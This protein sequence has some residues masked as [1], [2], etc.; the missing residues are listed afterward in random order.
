MHQAFVMFS[1]FRPD[2][3]LNRLVKYGEEWR[4]SK[5][6]PLLRSAGIHTCRVLKRDSEFALQLEPQARGPQLQWI[7]RVSAS[8]EGS[9]I[10]VRSKQTVW[11]RALNVGGL[12]FVS[13]F[14]V[15]WPAIK[16]GDY[17][18]QLAG[19]FLLGCVYVFVTASQ[20][21]RQ[22]KLCEAIL[23]EV[24]DAKREAPAPAA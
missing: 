5:I 23:V 6:P 16:R 9:R 8:P 3:V 24:I 22:R 1:A 17:W 10:D 15:S 19:L 7:G 4:E 11:S 12:L 14:V 13:F 2:D 20:S 21:S 18:F